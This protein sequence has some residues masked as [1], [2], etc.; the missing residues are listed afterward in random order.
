MSIVLP[1]YNSDTTNLHSHLN[2]E[3]YLLVQ[4]SSEKGQKKEK[5]LDPNQP[6]LTA[7]WDK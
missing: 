5:V 3:E 2:P 6:S 1:Y 7:E 4:S